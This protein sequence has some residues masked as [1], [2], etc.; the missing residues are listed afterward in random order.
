VF[1][2][3]P[4]RKDYGA[5]LALTEL[6]TA[7][8][9]PTGRREKELAVLTERAPERE[10]ANPRDRAR[11]LTLYGDEA[12]AAG[13]W[14]QA[15]ERYRLALTLDAYSVDAIVGSALAVVEQRTHEGASASL[16]DARK[17]LEAALQIDPKHVGA[18]VGLVRINLL[19]GR[20][21][22]A[23]DVAKKALD[24]GDRA[25]SVHYWTGKVLEDPAVNDLD[26]A[27]KEYKR[28]VELAPDEYAAY[29]A[30]SQLDLG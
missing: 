1:D 28:A 11:A 15:A 13:R 14:A 5:W 8:R 19:E 16:V 25:S 6:E 4:D 24:A 17:A 2:K 26:G 18:L 10:A 22:D 3:Y 30:L 29:V 7:P 21:A 23:R 27:E 12:M 9:D 20:A